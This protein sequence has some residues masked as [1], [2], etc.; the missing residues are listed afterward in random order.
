MPACAAVTGC[1]S[2]DGMPTFLEEATVASIRLAYFS[3]LFTPPESGETMATGPS[4][5]L[6]R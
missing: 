5:R 4:I 6:R 2:L 1:V 3:A